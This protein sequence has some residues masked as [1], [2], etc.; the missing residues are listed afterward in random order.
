MPVFSENPIF[1]N[2]QITIN[3]LIYNKNG[4]ENDSLISPYS[5]KQLW[6][7]YDKI[8]K[9]PNFPSFVDGTIGTDKVTKLC[10]NRLLKRIEKSNVFELAS[11]PLELSNIVFSSNVND[12]SLG[13]NNVL[14]NTLI[15]PAG[16]NPIIVDKTGVVFNMQVSIWI[17]DGIYNVVN[18]VSGI[19]STMVEPYYLTF[20]TYIGKLGGSGLGFTGPT[21]S[22][23]LSGLDGPTGP[24]GF[25]GPI[26]SAGPV[27]YID[28]STGL[29]GPTG[30]TGSTGPTGLGGNDITGP[31]GPTGLTGPTGP[32]CAGGIL[33]LVPGMISDIQG[34]DNGVSFGI[35]YQMIPITGKITTI[36]DDILA[37][38]SKNYYIETNFPVLIGSRIGI[39]INNN[40]YAHLGSVY[41]AYA[42][43]NS[44][45][46]N[47][48]GMVSAIGCRSLQ[49]VS[50]VSSASSVLACGHS[51]GS[52]TPT[53][54]PFVGYTCNNS[55]DTY[56]RAIGYDTRIVN[57]DT[58]TMTYQY[59]YGYKAQSQGTVC[60][61]LGNSSIQSLYCN[62]TSITSFSDERDKKD[63]QDLENCLQFVTK[64][65]P[66][67]YKWSPRDPCNTKNNYTIGFSA[68]DLLLNSNYLEY[69][70]DNIVD[71]S[72]PNNLKIKMNNM[73]PILVKAIQ[74]LI[75]INNSLE[76]IINKKYSNNI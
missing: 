56:I 9:T 47:V 55:S 26:G 32:K 64:I 61:V 62:V 19:P 14:R 24:T 58:N 4:S 3:T 44:G 50:N 33:T 11:N 59:I 1:I 23:G 54:S 67:S 30:E 63:I 49:N 13:L 74:E 29:T 48:C 51:A 22:A 8:N 36:G 7:E 42:M 41:G 28:L 16:Y 65:M 17:V 46:T 5:S 12:S 10:K 34:Y 71:N 69:G 27:T 37:N 70:I 20:V 72:D 43:S 53:G 31:T 6:I 76:K 73:I 18:F 66:I 60:C 45:S 21:G 52:L 40:Y 57:V 25:A 39:D 35:D 15:Q 68:Q 38:A 75:G 2:N